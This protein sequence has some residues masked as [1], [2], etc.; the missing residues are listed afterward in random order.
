MSVPEMFTGSELGIRLSKGLSLRGDWDAVNRDRVGVNI[1]NRDREE[2]FCQTILRHIM[3]SA[4]LH[5]LFYA[6]AVVGLVQ[7]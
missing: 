7:E 1:L 3:R 6:F 5:A 4:W 2:A